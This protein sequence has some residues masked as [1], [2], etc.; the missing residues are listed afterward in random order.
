MSAMYELLSDLHRRLLLEAL[1]FI[2][3]MIYVLNW[4]INQFRLCV[5]EIQDSYMEYIVVFLGMLMMQFPHSSFRT[6]RLCTA[7]NLRP[8]L[9][10]QVIYSV[11][12]RQCQGWC[13]VM[14]DLPY[15][16]KTKI[17]M[18]FYTWSISVLYFDDLASL[19][20]PCGR[21]EGAMHRIRTQSMLA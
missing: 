21:A 16:F 4:L 18:G 2:L 19:I 8:Y 13:E 12:L 20:V 6:I 14:S 3:F 5:I 11:Q 1:S 7:N 17:T 15:I 10:V 9:Y